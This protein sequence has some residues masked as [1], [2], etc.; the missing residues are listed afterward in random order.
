G[1][2][3][4]SDLPEG[5]T[6]VK[7]RAISG[8]GVASDR[9]GSTIVQVDKTNPSATADWS[10]Q[11]PWSRVPAAFDIVGADQ[12]GL[13]GMGSASPDEPL[14]KGAFV[15][16]RVEGGDVQHVGGGLARALMV[17]T[18]IIWSPI[19]PPIWQAASH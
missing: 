5:A 1:S 6:T 11:V 7:A 4:I 2:Y 17:A 14:E 3:R 16:Y 13:S 8:S 18:E 10:D 19:T 12:P 15:A 9:V